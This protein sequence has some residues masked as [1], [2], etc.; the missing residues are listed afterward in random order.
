M[1]WAIIMKKYWLK[2]MVFILSLGIMSA[3]GW[4]EWWVILAILLMGAVA[5]VIRQANVFL[6]SGLVMIVLIP[7]A[8]LINQ[9]VPLVLGNL[10][11]LMFVLYAVVRLINYEK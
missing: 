5:F 8:L 11:F 10:A 1:I 2:L 4:F 3:A 6:Y 9:T 7:L